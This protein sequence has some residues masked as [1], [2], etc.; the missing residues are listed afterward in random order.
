MRVFK[1]KVVYHPP[2]LALLVAVVCGQYCVEE[3]LDCSKD[4]PLILKLGKDSCACDREEHVGALKYANNSLYV[5]LGDKWSAIR[6]KKLYPY[7]TE[8]NPGLSCKDIRDKSAEKHLS[9]GVY[10]LRNE[11]FALTSRFPVYCDMASGGWTMVFKV[12]SGADGNVT[13][14][15]MYDS[16]DTTEE[17]TFSA[18]NDINI[19]MNRLASSVFWD[20]PYQVRVSV[21]ENGSAV[22]ELFFRGTGSDRYNWFSATRLITSS[23]VDIKTQPKNFFSLHGHCEEDSHKCRSFLINRESRD[24]TGDNGWLMLTGTAWCDWEG[25]AR[26]RQ[27]LYS[28]G[29]SYA[30]WSNTAYRAS[31]VTDDRNR[32]RLFFRS[33]I[34]QTN[35]KIC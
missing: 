22:K 3:T 4:V 15:Q 19:Y 5:C 27:I 12:V 9:D 24:C 17:F 1:M 34:W 11:G 29:S 7:G 32:G 28:K 14:M 21:Y 35:P 23:W 33:C 2:A 18:Q 20:S 30:M 10:W 8:N 31:F 6:L 26:H 16:E 13:A 25:G